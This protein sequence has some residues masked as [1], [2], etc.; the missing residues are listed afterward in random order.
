MSVR[1]TDARGRGAEP[2]IEGAIARAL[3]FSGPRVA[4][5]RT[6]PLRPPGDGELMVRSIVSLISPGSEML[7]YRGEANPHAAMALP[8][9]EGGGGFP[10]KCACQVVGRVEACGAGTTHAAGDLLLVRHPHQDRFVV[11]D[12]PA[13]VFPVPP[14]LPPERA[15]FANLVDV[16]VNAVLDVPIRI[17]DAVVVHDAGIVGS[18]C[19]QLAQATAGTVIVVDAAESRRRIALDWG[20]HAAVDPAGAPAAIRE[21]TA[22]R[23][24]DVAIEAT[25][26]TAGLQAAM[27]AT[28]VEGTVVA[29]TFSGSLDVPVPVSPHFYYRRQRLVSARVNSVGSGLQPRWD[30]ARRMEVGIS[31]LRSERVRVHATHSFPFDRAPEAYEL[32]DRHADEVMGITLT[33]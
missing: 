30:F 14:D 3:W 21:I 5:L 27:E 11:R 1:K 20:A 12:D 24:A 9:G 17:G 32:A 23:G 33:Y 6:E 25:G 29:V 13:L 18:L 16:A 4:D 7:I 10:V 26:T 31:L 28:G 8:T 22:A 2:G 19:A 15:V